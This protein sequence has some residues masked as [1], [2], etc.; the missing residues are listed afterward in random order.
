MDWE[1]W[2]CRKRGFG[3]GGGLY[4]REF[5]GGGDGAYA[6]REGR[7]CCS[8]FGS[9][10][11]SCFVRRVL[12]AFGIGVGVFFL[13]WLGLGTFAGMGDVMV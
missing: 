3:A 6:A 5:V 9:C 8:C 12:I 11:C 13:L 10:W 1:M 7:G 2:V 4:G